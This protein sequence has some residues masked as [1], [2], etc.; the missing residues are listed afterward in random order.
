MEKFVDFELAKKLKEKGY[1]QVKK[2]TLA[3]YSEKGEW[4]SLVSTLD[5]DYYSFEDFDDRDCVCPTIAQILTWLREKH[6]LHVCIDLDIDK[7]WFY[8]IESVN[9]DFQH[10]D[11]S[12]YDSYEKT[13]VS[14][15]HYALDK[16]I[17]QK[18]CSMKVRDLIELINN[19]ENLYCL[20]HVEDI[21]PKDIECVAE[22]LNKGEK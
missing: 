1:P 10:I 2:N 7:N 14:G 16:L 6:K 15:I 12:D 17:K 5:E 20:G 9:D 3:M 8:S 11:S 4:F 22:E 19:S 18:S 13:A 21:I